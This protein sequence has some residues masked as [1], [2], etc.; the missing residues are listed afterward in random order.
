MLASLKMAFASLGAIIRSLFTSGQEAELEDIRY[1]NAV[2]VSQNTILH[3]KYRNVKID[4]IHY[5]DAGPL[6]SAE[7]LAAVGDLP[8][9]WYSYADLLQ[10]DGAEEEIGRFV[11]PRWLGPLGW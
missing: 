6:P 7:I 11:R 10:Y 4:I 3:S 2:I 8:V 9:R 1:V 5:P